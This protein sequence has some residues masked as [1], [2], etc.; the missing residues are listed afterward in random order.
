MLAALR[1]R[2]SGPGGL[3]CA[4]Q[5]LGTGSLSKALTVHAGAFSESAKAAIEAAGGKAEVL[6]AKPKWTRG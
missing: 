1:A 6:A 3:C 4:V 5:V 2:L